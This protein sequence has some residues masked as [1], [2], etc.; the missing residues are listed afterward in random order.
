MWTPKYCFATY[1]STL[2]HMSFDSISGPLSLR[3]SCVVLRITRKCGRFEPLGKLQSE[4]YQEAFAVL[5][6][7]LTASLQE[8]KQAYRRQ[9]LQAHPDH[10][11]SHA[12]MVSLNRGYELAL[13]KGAGHPWA[14]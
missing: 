14:S 1:P 10:G 6:L 7:P 4:T 2:E 8:I 13:E 11:G 9:A 12:A 3:I 5:L